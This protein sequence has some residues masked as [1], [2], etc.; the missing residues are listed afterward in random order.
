LYRF[1]RRMSKQDALAASHD[2]LAKVQISDSERV[3]RRYPH[4]LSGGQQQRVM[5]AMALATDPDLLVLDEPTTGLDATVEAEV[6]EVV[7]RLRREFG[8]SV[9]FIS[10]NLAIVS[11]LCDRVG[12]LYAGRVVEE[13]PTQ[14]LFAQPRHPYTLALLRCVPRLGLRKDTR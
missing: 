12:V 8:A 7:G 5:I 6:L 14:E 2:M 9:L 4:E 11:R 13:G 3:G 10:H 1:H